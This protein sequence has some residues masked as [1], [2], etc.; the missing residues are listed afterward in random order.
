MSD[1]DA[2]YAKAY[3]Q[4]AGFGKKPALLLVD[5]VQAYF[6]PQCDLYADVDDALASALRVREAAHAAHVPVILTNVVYHHSAIDGG[7][8]YF[9]G[10]AGERQ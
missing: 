6:D 2:N 9:G 7:R 1:L 5:F 8:F 4:R 3:G 10:G